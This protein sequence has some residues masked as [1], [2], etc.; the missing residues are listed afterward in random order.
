MNDRCG[1]SQKLF[2]PIS[3][4]K[5]EAGAVYKAGHMMGEAGRGGE[6]GDVNDGGG[7]TLSH[8]LSIETG[9]EPEGWEVTVESIVTSGNDSTRGQSPDGSKIYSNMQIYINLC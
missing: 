5:A 6:R 7:A 1:L 8:L 9:P 3:Q 2:L 4:V